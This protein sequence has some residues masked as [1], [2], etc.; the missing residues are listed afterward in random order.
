MSYHGFILF[1]T[2]SWFPGFPGLLGFPGL[3]GARAPQNNFNV[4]LRFCNVLRAQRS[5]FLY[6][7]NVLKCSASSEEHV[8]MFY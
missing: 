8:L 4:L 7:T 2:V 3:P 5:M 6:F 1:F